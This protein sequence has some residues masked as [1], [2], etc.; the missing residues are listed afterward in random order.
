MYMLEEQVTEDIGPEI[1]G[2]EDLMISDDRE[3][4][5][6]EIEDEESYDRGK[7]HAHR[8]DIYMK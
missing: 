1:E 6:K 8:W 4:H 7:F 5:L 3:D 2:E